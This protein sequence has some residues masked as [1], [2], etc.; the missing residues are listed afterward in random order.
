MLTV[1]E[2]IKKG[3]DY[4]EDRS[5]TSRLDAEV[6]LRFVLGFT[7]TQLV[8]ERNTAISEQVCGKFFKLIERRRLGE[9]VAY[10]VGCKEFFG[11]E[12]K[13]DRHTLVP[14]PESEHLVEEAL[15]FIH[16]ARLDDVSILDLGTGSG[17]LLVT[18]I[19]ELAERGIRARGIGVDISAEALKIARENADKI[20]PGDSIVFK[21]G[22]WWQPIK[23]QQVFNVIV[24]NPPY[25]SI[26]DKNVATETAFEPQSALY[27]GLDGLDDYRAII[28]KVVNHLAPV[29]IFCGEFGC[30]QAQAVMEIMLTACPNLSIEIIKDIAGHDRLFKAEVLKTN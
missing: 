20:C 30:S 6:L 8:I 26:H 29:S 2:L 13:V 19:R 3:S 21:H 27:S 11:R 9:P 23:A 22:S 18:L 28:S 15:K 14:R 4:L 1:V 7:S 16:E 12:F 17:I 24:T 5:S 25:I 10:L